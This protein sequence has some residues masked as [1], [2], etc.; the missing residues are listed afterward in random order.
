MTTDEQ[1]E[2]KPKTKIVIKGSI[3]LNVVLLVASVFMVL[4]LAKES[5]CCGSSVEPDTSNVITS[6]EPGGQ[7][8]I[9]ELPKGSGRAEPTRDTVW[10]MAL[11][12]IRFT[13]PDWRIVYGRYQNGVLNLVA[14]K[15]RKDS[16]EI[17]SGTWYTPEGFQFQILNDAIICDTFPHP[18]PPYEPP[19]KL[20]HWFVEVGFEY[21][22]LDSTITFLRYPF[23]SVGG[24]LGQLRLGKT[25]WSLTPARL[26]W[27]G[28]GILSLGCALTVR[29]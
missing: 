9:P 5:G 25:S 6:K 24:E 13:I 2:D 26:T 11:D 29:F 18:P 28:G 16:S 14:V 12:T 23:V 17:Y 8:D 20:W 1:S 10:I 27:Q 3:I 22:A 4:M 21:A 15:P 7:P 19:V